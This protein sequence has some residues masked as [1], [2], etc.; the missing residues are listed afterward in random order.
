[1]IFIS[2]ESRDCCSI[3]HSTIDITHCCKDD[4]IYFMDILVTPYNVFE[5]FESSFRSMHNKL[6][7]VTKHDVLVVTTTFYELIL[8]NIQM[9]LYHIIIDFE[10]EIF[11]AVLTYCKKYFAT[12][13]QHLNSIL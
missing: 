7:C 8:L 3:K 11:D 13:E 2:F 9:H 1:M 12:L 4:I 5:I 6:I 10:L